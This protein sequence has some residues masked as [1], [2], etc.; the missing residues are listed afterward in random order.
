MSVVINRRL[1]PL[2]YQQ[3]W[4]AECPEGSIFRAVK[5][6]QASRCL[7]LKGWKREEFYT[8]H[9]ALGLED[10]GLL[11]CFKSTV[12]NEVRQAEALGV[13]FGLVESPE[14]FHRYYSA[15]CADR[16]IGTTSLA[17][18]R[19]L[20]TDGLLTKVLHGGRVLA[21][22][23]YLIDQLTGRARLLWSGSSRFSDEDKVLVAKANRWLHFQD[24]RVLRDRGFSVYD[25]GGIN[26]T[27][28]DQGILGINRFK[29][30]FG[31]IEVCEY[32]YTPNWLARILKA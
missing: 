12:R 15:F 8:L 31:G 28:Q 16:G 21:M 1:G 23:G 4:F 5:Y 22:H 11:A 13:S 32:H 24:M 29:Q 3:V 17:K 19:S 10:Q 26:P 2:P 6:F 27:S 25:W 7:E 9:S 30:A 18:V 14:E 20:G